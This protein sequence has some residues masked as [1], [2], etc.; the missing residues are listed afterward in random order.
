M[1]TITSAQSGNFNNTATWV[2]GVVPT[3]GDTAVAAA[4]HTITINSNVTCNEVT[5]SNTS[6]FF[7]LLDGY[8]LTANVTGGASLAN[9]GTLR[10]NGTTSANIVGNVQLTAGQFAIVL[11]NTGVLSITGTVFGG[12]TGSSPSAAIRSDTNGAR[13]TITGNVTGGVN[14]DCRGVDFR[15]G[16]QVVTVT[17]DVTG[18]TGTN[19]NAILMLTGANN[20]AVITGIVTGSGGPGVGSTGATASVSVT[21][22]AT[23]GATQHA[24]S[25]TSGTVSLAGDITD[26]QNGRVAIYAPVFA[27]DSTAPSG[28]TRYANKSGFPTGGTVSRVSPD[29]VTGMAAEAD[30]RAG[31]V[32][33]FDSQLEG[34]LAVPPANAVASGVPVDNTTGTA[35]LLLADVAAVTGAQIAAA[36]TAP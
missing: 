33:G 4:G 14:T 19:A 2:G 1:A 12:T 18:G 23:A 11:T 35:A 24:I 7:D 21:G 5:C 9:N 16:S 10:Y 29:N 25:V 15:S 36:V 6:G 26:N 20:S 17:G 3:T 8:T 27:L 34:T 13:V 30:V 31:T 32:Y 28:I 22:A